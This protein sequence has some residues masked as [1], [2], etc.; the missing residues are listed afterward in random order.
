MLSAA[1]NCLW[2]L[3]IING[4]FFEPEKNFHSFLVKCQLNITISS[5]KKQPQ[6]LEHRSLFRFS[7]IEWYWYTHKMQN[8]L[9]KL[10]NNFSHLL[11]FYTE[12]QFHM[13]WEKTTQKNEEPLFWHAKLLFLWG[14]Y[15]AC[16]NKSLFRK[17]RDW[18]QLNNLW[19][20]W[21]V[22]VYETLQLVNMPAPGNH[23]ALQESNRISVNSKGT[24]VE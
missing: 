17:S 19:R 15:A 1:L 7:F 23:L 3:S 13:R 11:I 4:H 16:K 20:Y 22:K 9:S 2:H 18:N 10:R 21:H 5:A 6:N 24:I 12:S 14:L 8:P